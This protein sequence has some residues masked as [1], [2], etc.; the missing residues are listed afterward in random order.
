MYVPILSPQ[1]P[2]VFENGEIFIATAYIEN[3]T[4]TIKWNIPG[5]LIKPFA[6]FAEKHEIHNLYEEQILQKYVRWFENQLELTEGSIYVT[7]SVYYEPRGK[8]PVN[9]INIKYNQTDSAKGI[10]KNKLSEYFSDLEQKSTAYVIN[11]E[12]VSI[13]YDNKNGAVTVLTLPEYRNKGYAVG[14]LKKLIALYPGHGLGYGTSIDNK[15]AIRV[16][17]KS[18]MTQTGTGYWIRV[19]PE[20]A[21]GL[22]HQKPDLFKNSI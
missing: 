22:C 20:A 1:V 7:T 11:N 12:I 5:P 17:E 9:D 21:N 16:A 4:C 6:L 13:A 19:Y 3:N 14:C 10:V 8:I 18:G 15:P 2:V